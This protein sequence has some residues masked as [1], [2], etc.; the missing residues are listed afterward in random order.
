MILVF[1]MFLPLICCGTPGHDNS[2]PLFSPLELRIMTIYLTG[3]L[4]GWLECLEQLP[5]HSKCSMRGEVVGGRAAAPA[6]QRSLPLQELTRLC[7]GAVALALVSW[8]EWW[9]DGGG[10]RG[11]NE[12][13]RQTVIDTQR[14]G[15]R[16]QQKVSKRQRHQ[17]EWEDSKRQRE[18]HGKGQKDTERLRGSWTEWRGQKLRRTLKT[19]TGQ[20]KRA[21]WLSG[22]KHDP[23]C[24]A[25]TPLGPPVCRWELC[26]HYLDSGKNT[27]PGGGESAHTFA[28]RMP[29]RVT[30]EFERE[31]KENWTRS[32]WC[33]ARGL[34]YWS[35]ADEQYCESFR[36][37]VKEFSHIYMCVCIYM[38][39]CVSILPQTPLS[40]RPTHNVAQSSLCCTVGPCC[41]SI[42]SRAVCTCPSQTPSLPLLPPPPLL[43]QLTL[44]STVWANFRAA[45]P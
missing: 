20:G 19:D 16:D 12:A 9:G 3:L 42:F 34:L 43:G 2:L 24:F 28:H 13:E 26:S 27:V 30:S 6:E 29:S 1:S 17:G 15:H 38:Y 45:K 7:Q 33:E 18:I 14:L 41:Q 44:H 21:H 11:K 39:I 4:W 25:L 35:I 5:G 23:R 22:L 36:W 32:T 8:G 10:R 31:I 37:T 40:S